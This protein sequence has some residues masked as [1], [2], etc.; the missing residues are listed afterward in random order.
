MKAIFLHISDIHI[1]TSIDPILNM[2]GKIAQATY[3]HLD[4]KC[5]LIILVTGDIVY[6]GQKEQYELAKTFL[7]KIASNIKSERNVKINFIVCPGNHDCDFTKDPARDFILSRV[8]EENIKDVPSEVLASCTKHQE[9][10][11]SFK[12]EIESNLI[13]EDKLWAT[14]KIEVAS[15]KFVF[16]SINLAWASKL[17][18]KSGQLT[19]PFSAYKN[20]G[21]MECDFR[22]TLMHHPLNWLTQPS[23][24]DFRE[25]LRSISNFVFTGHEHH[26]NA[27]NYDDIESGNTIIIEGGALQERSIESS[28]FGIITIDLKSKDSVYQ[29]YEYSTTNEIYEPTEQKKLNTES[30]RRKSLTISKTFKE[31]IEDCGAHYRHNNIENLKLPD[32]FTYPNIRDELKDQDRPQTI[33]AKELLDVEKFSKG[34]II[35]GEN[36]AGRTSLLHTLFAEYSEKGYI[37]ILINGRDLKKKESHNIDIQIERAI[38]EQYENNN[39]V[40]LFHQEPTIKK[41]LLIDDFNESKIKSE[42]ALNQALTYLSSNFEK[43]ILTVDG[44]FGVNELTSSEENSTSSTFDHFK[45]E[46]FGYKKRTE[47]INRWYALGQKDNETEAQIIGKCNTAEKLMDSVMDKS[48]ISSNPIFLL[49]FLQSIDA[50]DSNQLSDSALGHYYEYL[51]TQS[52]L[53]A[54]ISAE[55]LGQELDYAMHLAFLFNRKDSFSITTQE[56]KEFNKSFSDKWQETAFEKKEKTLLKAKVLIKKNEEYEFR[57]SYNY[58]FLLGRYLSQNILNEDI[59]PIIE[60]CVEHLYVR[61]N[62]NTILFLAHHSS[63]DNVLLLMKKATDLLFEESS[64]ADFSGQCNAAH[65]LI[66]HAPELEYENQ[67]PRDYRNKISEKRDIATKNGHKDFLKD[68][69]EDPKNLDLATK[70]TMLFKTIDILSQIIKSNP[71]KF[72]RAKK[73]EILKSALSA[74]LRALQSFYDFL[75]E[76]PVALIKAIDRELSKKAS[77]IPEE[78]RDKIARL[79]VAKII[80][81]LSSAFI[82]KTAQTINSEVLMPDIPKAISENKNLAFELVDLSISLDNHKPLNKKKVLSTFKKC[83]NNIVAKKVLD[84][85]IIQRLYMYKTTEQ[86]M[87]WLQSELKYD[88]SAQHSIGYTKSNKLARIT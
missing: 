63:S 27:V 20:K 68:K 31:K 18:E 5:H 33:S 84:V 39:S 14:Y 88:L 52:F 46:Q 71:T 16:E 30:I 15:K 54:G 77:D 35:S 67:S 40:N 79:V 9:N 29:K 11:F 65:E 37:P 73:V 61:K 43:I 55:H 64:V 85:I 72:E 34:I 19:F 60:N 6:S 53:N 80:Q 78:D 83:E 41:I 3:R 42:K 59:R 2:D 82:I 44:M 26:N 13:E 28:S 74:P 69:E 50:G 76:H 38:V 66:K 24:R 36:N 1:K 57:Y 21:Q 10:Y 47:L 86:D 45:I 51:L 25:S 22:I 75:E 87:Q 7:E 32:I 4:N 8:I 23:Y 17:K 62:A 12:R 58:Y 49:T 56:F 48:L 81:G 70:I